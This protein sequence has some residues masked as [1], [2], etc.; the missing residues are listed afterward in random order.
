MVPRIV[1][2]SFSAAARKSAARLRVERRHRRGRASSSSST[3]SASCFGA[4]RQHAASRTPCAAV[5]DLGAIVG[6]DLVPRRRWST[7]SAPTS[8]ARGR[9]AC[10]S[11]RGRSAAR[12]ARYGGVGAV[13]IMPVG[14]FS[15]AG[16]SVADSATGLKPFALYHCTI[17][18][19]P[20]AREELRGLHVGE[21]LERLLREQLHPAAAAPAERAGSPWRSS[22][23][24]SDRRQLLLHVQ[25]FGVALRRR[26]ACRTR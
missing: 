18:S 20:L 7:T 16:M 1:A 3:E 22:R 8:G 15:C 14:S 6:V 24:S 25:R 10:T 4:S 19:S 9:R 13:S 21:R 23:C 12:S 2:T 5:D 17:L 11:R 26:T